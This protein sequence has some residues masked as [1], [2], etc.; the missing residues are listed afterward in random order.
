VIAIA[1]GAENRAAVAG[2]L[3]ESSDSETV[4]V[5]GENPAADSSERSRFSIV[6]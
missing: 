5:S 6:A 1:M 4:A 2:K 3:A